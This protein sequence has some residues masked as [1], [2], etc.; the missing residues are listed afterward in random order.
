[1]TYL[2]LT[3]TLSD[4]GYIY[5]SEIDMFGIQNILKGLQQRVTVKCVFQIEGIASSMVNTK[6]NNTVTS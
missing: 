5:I 2:D 6:V 1:M 4:C 3:K